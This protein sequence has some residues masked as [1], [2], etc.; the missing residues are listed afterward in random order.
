V[1][2]AQ[3]NAR[4]A[5]LGEKRPTAPLEAT[6]P[7]A[8]TRIRLEACADWAFYEEWPPLNIEGMYRRIELHRRPD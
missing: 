4:R 2:V 8:E 7:E 1:I 3:T 6:F 5:I